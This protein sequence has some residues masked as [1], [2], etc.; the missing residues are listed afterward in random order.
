ME[1]AVVVAA[2]R[3]RE[4]PPHNFHPFVLDYGDDE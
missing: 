1:P 4:V 2:E 3:Y